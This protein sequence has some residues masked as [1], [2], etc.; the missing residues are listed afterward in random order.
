M[1]VVVNRL[2][3][4]TRKTGIGHYTD[5]LLR[6]LAAQAGADAVD[7]FPGAWTARLWTACASAGSHLEARGASRPEEA[8]AAAEERWRARAARHLRGLGF[9]GVAAWFRRACRRKGYQLYHEPNT[10]PMPAD[11]PA[12]ATVHDL[13]VLL[14]PEWHPAGRVRY[15]EAHLRQALGGC[16][17]VLAV[18]D[19]TRREVIRHL[20]IP[21]QRV[22]R[23][24][25]G[26][27][28]GYGPLPPAVV[29][30]E[31]RRL[32]L[33]AR[34]LLCVGTIEPRKNLHMLLR[35]YCSLPAALRERWP[36]VLSGQWGWNSGPVARY[37]EDTA[38][39]RGVVHAGYTRDD[40]LA[41]LYNG[42]RAL[43]YPSLHEGFGLPPLEMMATGGAV[44][45]SAAGALVETAGGQAC[46]LDPDDEAAWRDAVARVVTDDEWWNHLRAGAPRTAARYTWARSAAETW[47]VYQAVA[48]GRQ[49]D[50]PARR[51][52]G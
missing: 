49:A 27:R 41:V 30:R 21:P 29:E 39:H 32:R 3:A 17:H 18:S 40:T 4:L 33:P 10:I 8:G 48:G 5:E 28:P 45:A 51:A 14:H 22:T 16:A 1:R 20:G 35:A 36:L 13:S 12:V 23:V 15:H 11:C 38:R 44:L 2:A 24:Y 50:T 34:F 42:A 52:A 25:N 19:F 43:L 37:F 6:C 46:L 9:A 7:T 26:V 47:Q 31:L